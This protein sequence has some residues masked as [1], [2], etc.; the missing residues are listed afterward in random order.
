MKGYPYMSANV[1]YDAFISYRHKE[2]DSFVAQNLHKMLEHFHIPRKIQKTSGKKKIERIFRDR[3]ELPLTA[4][5]T[6]NI[7]EALLHSEYLIVICSP[8]A[9]ESEWVQREIKLFLETHDKEHVLTILANGEPQEAFPEVLC[10]NEEIVVDQNG[11][12]IILKKA[13]EPLAADVRGKDLKEVKKKLKQEFFR[14]LAPML[15]CT[16]DDLR[17]RHREYRTRIA[18]S[19]A[20]LFVALALGFTSYVLTQ[21]AR[22]KEQY[23]RA[24]INQS[25]Y[26]CKI[27]GE[28]LNAGDRK[29]ALQTALASLPP[30]G[31]QT[32]TIVPESIYALN[33][34][35]YSYYPESYAAFYP[36]W[37]LDTEFTLSEDGCFNTDGSYYAVID[38][39]GVVYIIDCESESFSWILHA[40]DIDEV[41]DNRFLKGI[42]LDDTSLLLLTANYWI[43]LDLSQHQVVQVMDHQL[44][45]TNRVK[46]DVY[47]TQLALGYYGK[48]WIY[49]LE[50][51]ENQLSVNLVENG[52]FPSFTSVSFHPD[53]KMLAVGLSSSSSSG[54]DYEG[55]YLLDLVDGSTQKITSEKV[56]GLKYLTDTRITALDFLPGGAWDAS[57]CIRLYDAKTAEIIWESEESIVH[58]EFER[59]PDMVQLGSDT[60]ERLL[61]LGFLREQ[62]YLVDVAS[63]EL[64][65]KETYPSTVVG[66]FK[67]SNSSLMVG[68]KDGTVYRLLPKG[69]PSSINSVNLGG[70]QSETV[71]FSYHPGPHKAIQVINGE[72][73]VIFLAM[74]YDEN[75]S[76]VPLEDLSFDSV[77]YFKQAGNGE[78]D[79]EA[80]Y[81]TIL[82]SSDGIP[83]LLTVSDAETNEEIYRVD[84]SEAGTE[85]GNAG[86]CL[87]GDIAFL[88]YTEQSENFTRFHVVNLETQQTICSEELPYDPE[89]I[90]YPYY[91]RFV[92]IQYHDSFSLFNLET[93]SWIAND[94]PAETYISSID[95]TP[96]EQYL[97]IIRNDPESAN[98]D[99]LLQLWDMT[100]KQWYTME[101]ASK[102]T[103]IYIS[104]DVVLGEVTNVAA[105]YR[106][107]GQISIT[108][109]M[110]G[111]ILKTIPLVGASTHKFAFTDQDQYLLTYGDS[112]YLSIWD[113]KTGTE[114]MRDAKKLNSIS[115]ITTDPAG[116]WFAVKERS[117][118]MTIIFERYN[119]DVLHIYN[120]DEDYRFYRY[121][122]VP[123]GYV[124]F[125]FGKIICTDYRDLLI[126][127]PLYD[128][129]TLRERAELLLGDEQLTETQKMTYFIS[130]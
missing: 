106:S 95:M 56:F 104:G 5:L 74:Q 12:E 3:E 77:G 116:K 23:D 73:Q 96:D 37:S 122:D 10:Y 7:E 39:S 71:S 87:T 64:V 129:E 58:T 105:I 24:M 75:P 109:L 121:A 120:L 42:F 41:S 124:D 51:N 2:L 60:D 33:N 25:R 66:A 72:A 61:L 30:K 83:N 101:N 88:C 100:K 127:A 125:E 22:I 38:D 52:G 27:S 99:K 128:I 86:I 49:N 126:T 82:Y 55:I 108:D 16:Y 50:R 114:V 81:R 68:T 119:Q 31:D 103:D 34:A 1:H 79:S 20:G 32:R 13:V 92:I 107:N 76:N 84:T 53:G 89:A 57:W 18:L 29:G 102:I 26:L 4:D 93:L 44:G 11:E 111:E 48:V 54:Y 115:S 90:I 46:L 65:E 130:E 47:D 67:E 28:L 113:L 14:I 45:L 19:A 35:L 62:L 8:D 6:S 123:F 98:L 9:N 40:A 59:L 43:T 117:N 21:N 91:H 78:Q 69:N 97:T 94:F 112:G 80:F 70:I 15:S 118:Y 17:Q 36:D 85:L 110:T 63:G